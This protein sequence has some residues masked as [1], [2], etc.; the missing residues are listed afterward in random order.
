MSV[1]LCYVVF[2]NAQYL[3]QQKLFIIII[4]AIVYSLHFYKRMIIHLSSFARCAYYTIKSLFLIN[5]L[6]TF[7]QIFLLFHFLFDLVWSL[8]LITSIITIFSSFLYYI[9]IFSTKK[10]E[11]DHHSSLK[12]KIK[13]IVLL[14]LYCISHEQINSIVC[15]LLLIIDLIVKGK[16][17]K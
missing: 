13:L 7:L 16:R 4:N 1:V 17:L 15:S 14:I 11:V 2:L 12:T 10:K 8:F 6:P 5:I 9:L 3:I